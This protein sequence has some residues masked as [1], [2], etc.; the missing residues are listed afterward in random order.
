MYFNKNIAFSSAKALYYTMGHEFVHVSQ[1]AS[2]AG[3][4][5]SIFKQ[6]GF[7][8]MLEYHAYS[9]EYNVLGSSNYGGF[10]NTRVGELMKQFP[11]F[12]TYS[13]MNY[14]WTTNHHFIFP[15]K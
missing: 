13:Y 7:I 12:S 10:T 2:L 6:D 11:D 1:Y 14:P 15:I 8:D 4:A 3:K 9:Y 5:S